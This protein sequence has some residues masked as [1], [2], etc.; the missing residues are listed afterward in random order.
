MINKSSA[1]VESSLVKNG[2]MTKPSGVAWIGDMPFTWDLYRIKD[3]EITLG[4]MLTVSPSSGD[5]VELSYVRSANISTGTLDSSNLKRMWFKPNE[6]KALKIRFNDVL[7]SEG[8][9]V[10]C[11]LFVAADPDETVCM[12]NSVNRIR[13]SWH[14]KYVYFWMKW[15]YDS[16]QHLN[17]INT[18]SIS[19]LTKEKLAIVP[20]LVPPLP[21][22]IAIAA[23]LDK[24]TA[25][26]DKQRALL[27]RKKALLQEHKKA[28]IHEA[29]TKGLT[30]GVPM[31]SSGV[32]WIGDVPSHWRLQRL[33]EILYERGEKNVRKS[34]HPVTDNILSVMKDRGV[35]NYKDK[36]NV[37]NKMSDDISVYKVVHSGDLVVNKMNILIG[38]YGISP[39]YGALSV[40]YLVLRVRSGFMPFWGCVFGDKSFQRGLRKI[41]T[42]ILEIR[43][44]VNMDLF[45]QESVP[46]PPVEEQEKI[47][48]YLECINDSF[49]RKDLLIRRKLDLLASLRASLI[50]EAVT[51]G[52]PT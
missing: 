12:Q 18:V 1:D 25:L 34:G 21:E 11:P 16:G 41:A 8:G 29:V 46:A 27:E 45:W 28:L 13:S 40:V 19:H 10:G 39:E 24:T 23:Y 6:V 43:E 38:S 37:G 9:N 30:P 49:N 2:V 31:K 47:S 33:K 48:K 35:I 26:I 3:G 50:H 44:A 52:V 7:I 4:K 17:N 15:V 32:S 51:K 5:D 36:G 42:G 14:Q 20:I 22:Q